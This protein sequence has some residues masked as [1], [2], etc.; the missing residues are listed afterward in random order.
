[1]TH[2]DNIVSGSIA[3]SQRIKNRCLL[4]YKT[5]AGTIFTRIA[6]Q[7]DILQKD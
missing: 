6:L 4:G 3:V 5:Q 7:N 2:G 1:M